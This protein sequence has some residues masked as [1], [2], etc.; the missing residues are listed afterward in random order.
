MI[1]QRYKEVGSR[2]QEAGS[3]WKATQKT[4]VEKNKL[5]YKF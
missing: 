2:M 4:Y 3:F 1:P 5:S